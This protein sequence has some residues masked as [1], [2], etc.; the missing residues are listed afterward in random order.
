MFAGCCCAK[1]DFEHRDGHRVM[2]VVKDTPQENLPFSELDALAKTEIEDDNHAPSTQPGPGTTF[3]ARITRN[4]EE[5][6]GLDIDLIDG[7]SA[8]VVDIKEGAVKSWNEMNPDSAI[9]VND[10][11]VQVNGAKHE[12]NLLV[13]N[14]KQETQWNL[15]V[16]RP[17]MF[18]VSISR[19]EA[20]SL[21]MDLRYAPNGT[22]LMI[23][24]VGEGPMQEWNKTHPHQQVT[25]HDRIIQLNGVRGTPTTLLHASEDS[26]MLDMEIVHYPQIP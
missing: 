12:A 24:H 22:T 13:S 19:T 23:T 21:G 26:S 17:A 1:E 3:T 4:E 14:L 11:I 7:V 6:I 10:R 15:E 18:T 16:Q 5:P 8:V 9:R 25:R 2:T 20:Q